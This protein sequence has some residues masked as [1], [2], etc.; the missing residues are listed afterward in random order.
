MLGPGLCF[1]AWVLFFL[2]LGSGLFFYRLV[3]NIVSLECN[4]VSLP[5][6]S[7]I[8]SLDANLVRLACSV[9]IPAGCSR[10]VHHSETLE[11][12]LRRV[13]VRSLVGCGRE[14]GCAARA[15][16]E[17]AESIGPYVTKCYIEDLKQKLARLD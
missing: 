9:R 11:N 14:R 16:S 7:N 1:I 10:R 2:L 4:P 3:Y 13:R 12:A 8:V 5:R 17:S 6:F 15:H